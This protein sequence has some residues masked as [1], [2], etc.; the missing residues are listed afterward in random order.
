VFVSLNKLQ[1]QLG[2]SE[3][4]VGRG[5]LSEMVVLQYQL[6]TSETR[7]RHSLR[8]RRTDRFNTSL[9]RLKRSTSRIPLMS[10][11]GFNTSLVRLKHDADNNPRIALNELQYQL[12][13]SE[14]PCELNSNY[15]QRVCFNTSLVR[16]KLPSRTAMW[17][18]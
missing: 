3:T 8:G 11:W 18:A 9:V 17:P 2:T 5:A 15:F 10:A 6:G 14:T 12:G 13:T 16:L 4:G 1:Y 7:S